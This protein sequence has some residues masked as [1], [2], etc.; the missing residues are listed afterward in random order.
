M[1]AFAIR[2]IT[3]FVRAETVDRRSGSSGQAPF[4]EEIAGFQ[5]CDHGFLAL[6]G[7]DGLLDLAA[8][9][10]ENRI[11]RFALRVD[12][13]ILP[14]IGNAPVHRLLS[15]RN[16]LGSNGSFA[17]RFIAGHHLSDDE[18]S[19]LRQQEHR[20]FWRGHLRRHVLRAVILDQF[21]GWCR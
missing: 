13:L 6:L 19:I 15:T 9:N 4:A 17:L 14:I 5:K 11:R 1:S 21:R 18:R 7:D 3:H 10:V 8:L 20:S 16:T 12:N 2:A